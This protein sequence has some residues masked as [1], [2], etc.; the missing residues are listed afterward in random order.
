MCICYSTFKLF[1]E[2]A[3]LLRPP[4]VTELGQ[5]LVSL[6]LS[7]LACRH[8][9]PVRQGLAGSS[10]H[11]SQGRSRHAGLLPGPVHGSRTAERSGSQPAYGS[12]QAHSC[13][14]ELLPSCWLGPVSGSCAR[15]SAL[16]S[17]ASRRCHPFLCPRAIRTRLLLPL[18]FSGRR[19]Q[20]PSASFE[21]PRPAHKKTLE[22]KLNQSGIMPLIMTSWL[23]DG[24]CLLG[25][26]GPWLA[27]VRAM[28]YGALVSA[29]CEFTWGAACGPGSRAQKYGPSLQQHEWGSLQ[30]GYSPVHKQLQT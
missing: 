1:T 19:W 5:W 16:A 15:E 17:P 27:G 18:Q 8:C 23:L 2:S 12:L 4:E 21:E 25:P 14:G 10:H 20:P 24:L 6:T 3:P 7:S 30:M 28:K 11:W 26:F 13:R 9:R 29:A 22:L